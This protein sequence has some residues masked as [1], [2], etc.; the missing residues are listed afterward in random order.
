M[1]TSVCKHI[2]KRVTICAYRAGILNFKIWHLW[3]L[4]KA[5]KTRAHYVKMR[6]H[7]YRA[8]FTLLSQKKKKKNLVGH[9]SVLHYNPPLN[10]I[11]YWYICPVV[12]QNSTIQDLQSI[13]YHL[14]LA[15]L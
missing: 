4:V 1:L 7:L 15:E 5:A 9:F 6:A 3:R 10:N 14:M 13:S 11:K 8:E 12:L 2:L